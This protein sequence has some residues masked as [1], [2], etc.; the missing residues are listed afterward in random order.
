[1]QKPLEVYDAYDA[2]SEIENALFREAKQA[3]FIERPARNNADA[4]RSHVYLTV[5]MMALTAAFQTWMDQQDK[6]AQKGQE[7]GIRKFREKVRQENG[8]KLIVFEGD[9]YAIFDAYEVFILCGTNVRMPTGVPES[10][11]KR[12]ILLKYGALRE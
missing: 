4:F 3:W 12:D 11:S 2:R 5:L 1:M 10:I 9:R 8:N 7:T 6:L